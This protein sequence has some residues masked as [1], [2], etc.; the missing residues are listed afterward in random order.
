MRIIALTYALCFNDADT[1]NALL[2]EDF[3]IGQ[4]RL[5]RI[6][7]SM[8]IIRRILVFDRK[9]ADAELL[10]LVEQEYAKENL[11]GFGKQYIHMHF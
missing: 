4:T 1:L 3:E 11:D 2:K 10:T 7:K 5:V 8:G 6:R 9:T